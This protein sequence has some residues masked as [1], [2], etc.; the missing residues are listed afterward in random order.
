MPNQVQFTFALFGDNSQLAAFRAGAVKLIVELGLEG[1][2]QALG[3]I[4]PDDPRGPILERERFLATDSDLS[5]DVR[6]LLACP[7]GE[8]N[9]KSYERARNCLLRAQV[10][11]L[12]DLLQKT[13][14]DLLAITNFGQKSLDLVISQ[15]GTLGLTLFGSK[16]VDEAKQLTEAERWLE[17][18]T[19]TPR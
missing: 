14:D 10:D 1:N 11:T 13:E 4:D 7:D 12:G 18:A 2:I 17:A 8:I 15:L 9:A 16:P 3:Q 6:E 19:A 5:M